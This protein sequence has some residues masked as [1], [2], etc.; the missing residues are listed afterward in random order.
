MTNKEIV[1]KIA[2]QSNVAGMLCLIARVTERFDAVQAQRL[3]DSAALF[4][5]HSIRLIATH[6]LAVQEYL[7]LL[8]RESK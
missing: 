4:V 6:K 3:R 2:I 7:G 5:A 1:R 8:K